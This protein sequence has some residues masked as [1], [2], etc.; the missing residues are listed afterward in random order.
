MSIDTSVF[1]SPGVPLL[2]ELEQAGFD[3]TVRRGE[4]WVNPVDQLTAKQR[5]SIQ[6]YRNELLTLVQCCDEGVQK[7]L[8]SF[9]QQ[10]SRA[11]KQTTPAFVFRQGTPWA[12]GS[13]F[14]CAGPL[15]EQRYGRCWRCSLAWRMAAGVSI[16][17]EKARA[18]DEAR[19]LAYAVEEA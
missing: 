1:D 14:S 13:C 16:P 2:L 6:L 18:Y 11:P 19:V 10:L 7:R 17:A 12:K 15:D 4:L 9:K 8:A 5:A 3:F